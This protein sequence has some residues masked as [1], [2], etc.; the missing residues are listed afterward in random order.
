MMM[1]KYMDQH[2]RSSPEMVDR[3]SNEVNYFFNCEAV[4][5]NGIKVLK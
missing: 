3:I 5:E 4:N 2:R 1:K